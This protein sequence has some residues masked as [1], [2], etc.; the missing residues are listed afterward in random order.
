MDEVPRRDL[1]AAAVVMRRIGA[2]LDELSRFR[3]SFWAYGAHFEPRELP[4]DR[5]AL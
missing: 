3:G 2:M 5:A 1:E 4:P